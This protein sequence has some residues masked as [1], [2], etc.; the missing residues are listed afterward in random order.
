VEFT[1]QLLQLQHGV[2]SPGTMAAL[3]ALEEAGALSSEDR[4]VLA[5][6]YRF[7]ERTRNRLFLVRGAPGDALPGRPEQL[8]RLARSLGTGPHELREQYRRATRRARAVVE[9]LFYDKT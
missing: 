3:A 5:E 8:T 1:T 4:T 6:A 7:C 9:R 2:R